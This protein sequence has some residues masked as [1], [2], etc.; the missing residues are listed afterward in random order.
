[1][2][3]EYNEI[4]E[5]LNRCMVKVQDLQAAI[6]VETGRKRLKE[7]E[8]QMSKEGFWTHGEKAQ[9]VIAER[10]RLLGEIEPLD[11]IG[12]KTRDSLELAEIAESE[13][14]TET[15]AEIEAD[16]ETLADDLD[17]L[18]L[19]ATLSGQHDPNSAFLS[20]HAGAGGTESCDWAAMLARMYRRFAERQGFDVEMVDRLEGE[21]A[22]VKNITFHVKGA[23]AHGYLRSEIGVHRLVRKSPFDAK[24]KRHT[25]FAAVDVVP[26]V[27]DEG[28]EVEINPSELRIDTFRAGGAGGQHVNVTDSAVRITHLP[29]GIVVQ[30]QNERSQHANR[31][32]AIKVLKARLLADKERKREEELEKLYGEKGEIAWGNQIRS[33]VL[34]PYTLVKDRRTG[35]EE[36]NV[37]AV[38]DGNI[39]PF[40]EAYLRWKRG[41]RGGTP[42]STPG[43]GSDPRIKV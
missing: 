17:R 24:N 25:S 6:D 40:V 3:L 7:L 10:K 22:G 43:S 13:D 19:K 36:G 23:Y 31:A 4:V 28:R 11:D 34:E 37:E 20:V 12:R 30:C 2:K 21:E 18:E 9:A 8:S 1:M 42:G 38:L 32:T 27:E 15:L 14:D 41:Q 35:H 39:F 5:R 29:T 16:L 26:E 33:Y